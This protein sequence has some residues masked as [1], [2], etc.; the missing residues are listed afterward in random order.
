MPNG[1]ICSWFP[2]ENS[3][4][5]MGSVV[6]YFRILKKSVIARLSEQLKSGTNG[7]K[8]EMPSIFSS[9]LLFSF[10]FSNQQLQCHAKHCLKLCFTITLTEESPLTYAVCHSFS[11]HWGALTQAASYGL[12]F[13]LLCWGQSNVKFAQSRTF[14]FL[15]WDWI[16]EKRKH[17]NEPMPLS[18]LIQRSI[19]R[20]AERYSILASVWK[21]VV[22][23][24]NDSMIIVCPKK[25]K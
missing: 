24:G 10:F 19:H 16:D 21:L 18:T 14:L 11:S 8:T 20:W 12:I 9:S 1:R 5:W 4:R 23:M 2:V 13:S 15:A 7:Q 25:W 3:R 6:V 17:W 22:Q